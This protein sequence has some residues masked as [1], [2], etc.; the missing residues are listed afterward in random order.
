MAVWHLADAKTL[1]AEL[2][3]DITTGLTEEEAARRLGVYGANELVERERRTVWHILWE[4]VRATM[5]VIL[6]V[7]CRSRRP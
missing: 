2:E 4:Q 3:T 1:T 7:V 5:V 6:I